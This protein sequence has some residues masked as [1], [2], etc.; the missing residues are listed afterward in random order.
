MPDRNN[1]E[2]KRTRRGV[3]L[4][5]ATTTL[6]GGCSATRSTETE[7]SATVA[8]TRSPSLTNTPTPDS[9]D[10]E[11]AV[12]TVTEGANQTTYPTDQPVARTSII[13]PSNLWIDGN[14]PLISASDGAVQLVQSR[15]EWR[16]VV[17][18]ASG[19]DDVD[20]F[21][22]SFV[23]R[24]EFESKTIVF[25]QHECGGGEWLRL[26]SING[27]GTPVLQLRVEVASQPKIQ[28]RL[29]MYVFVRLPTNGRKIKQITATVE[30][31][32]DSVQYVRKNNL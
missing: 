17:T 3:L 22:Y 12:P 30:D 13:R 2:R 8:Q 26:L 9:S 25:V 14:T 1:C 5:V 6:F 20:P 18:E 32:S 29:H 21:Q 27:V 15:A 24:T 28:Q 11:T 16:Q 10:T 31:G 19:Y 23:D 4:R 7:S